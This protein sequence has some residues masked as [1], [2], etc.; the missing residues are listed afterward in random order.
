MEIL[1]F[2]KEKNKLT[3]ICYLARKIWQTSNGYNQTYEKQNNLRFG[4]LKF[5]L[6]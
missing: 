6:S 1:K 3:Y 5:K 2:L 4:F